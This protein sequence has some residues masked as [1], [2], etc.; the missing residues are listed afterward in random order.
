MTFWGRVVSL[1][2]L[3]YLI[4]N[5]SLLY[6]FLKGLNLLF[7][8]LFLIGIYLIPVLIFR[9]HN[10][11]FPLEDG[12][13]DLSKKQYNSWWTSHM[14]Q[15]PFIAFP[16]LES[17]LHFI[18]GLYSLWLRMWGAKIGKKVFWTPRV[19]ILDRSLIEIGS[20]TLVGHLCIFVSHLVETKTGK[21]MLVLKKISIGKYCLVSA[22]SQLGPGAVLADNTKLKPKTRLYW[23][24]EWK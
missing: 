20:Y 15:Y 19:E 9:L 10:Y 1:F 5:L 14:L 22:D 8:I 6:N 17:I 11:F 7:F 12:D 24:G 3:M 23:R 13:Y 4:L 21:P 2:P 18:P 16:F